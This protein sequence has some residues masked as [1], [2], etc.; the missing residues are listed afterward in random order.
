MG[1]LDFDKYF[2]GMGYWRP[3]L[4]FAMPD[5]NYISP[6]S[7]AFYSLWFPISVPFCSFAHSGKSPQSKVTSSDR[8]DELDADIKKKC[9]TVTH[10][11]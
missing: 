4:L 8:L 5:I 7:L 10:K 1:A 3:W 9:A 11:V 6:L 2:V